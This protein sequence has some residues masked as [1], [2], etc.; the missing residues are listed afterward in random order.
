[1][2]ARALDF[3]SRLVGNN[4]D[5]VPSGPPSLQKSW[6]TPVVASSYESLLSTASDNYNRARLR[7]VASPHAGDWLKAIP[8]SSLGLRLN[9]EGLR[10]AVGLRLGANLCAPFTCVCGSQVDARGA[11]GLSCIKSAGR[12]LRH[13]LVNDEVL[14]AFTRAGVPA[15]REPTGLIP[16]SQLRPDG[17]TVIPWSQGRCL[18]WDVTCPDTLATSHL[19]GCATS[20]GSAAES[21]AATK[22]HKYQQLSS[23]HCFT[24]VA[25]ET[26]GPINTHGLAL[27]TT[28]GGR[29]IA[30]TGDPRERMFF[31][32]RLSMAIQ[33]GNIA[34]FT[35]SLHKDL[36]F[37]ESDSSD[38]VQIDK[39]ATHTNHRGGST[40]P[41]TPDL[42]TPSSRNRHGDELR[43]C[44]MSTF[45]NILTSA[46]ECASSV[47]VHQSSNSSSDCEQLL[48]VHSCVADCACVCE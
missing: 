39:G 14:R 21:A 29:C 2:V 17:A 4:I 16:T 1:M 15:K 30:A 46:A 18:A 31:F 11:H 44:V 26:L 43:V 41:W 20:A 19:S 33:R 48:P 42:C 9:D 25:I 22:I 7:A 40:D 24:P 36:F 12:Q 38:L 32:Q 28:L 34:C 47:T 37:T 13:S 6:D 23:T 45:G 27:L 35:G 8:S 5:P 3:W 10:I